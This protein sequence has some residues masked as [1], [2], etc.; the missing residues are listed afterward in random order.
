MENYPTVLMM[1][2][3]IYFEGA[4]WKIIPKLSLLIQSTDVRHL[5]ELM[6]DG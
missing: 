2:H 3:N 4:V 6:V 5:W 1:S